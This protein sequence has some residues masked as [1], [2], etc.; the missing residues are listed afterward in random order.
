MPVQASREDITDLSHEEKMGR[1]I[2]VIQ[3]I[4]F[5]LSHLLEFDSFEVIQGKL[6]TFTVNFKQ[7]VVASLVG[8]PE[9]Y[10]K[11]RDMVMQ[12]LN[13]FLDTHD[14]LCLQSQKEI[15]KMKN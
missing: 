5:D 15:K 7:L 11:L 10:R 3:K 8:N 12:D 13:G 9:A 2:T 6:L 4:D 14:K 1:L